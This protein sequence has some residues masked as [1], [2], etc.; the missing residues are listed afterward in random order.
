MTD[1]PAHQYITNTARTVAEVRSA[2]DDWLM[3]TKE[4]L[5]GSQAQRAPV[6]T[7]LAADEPIIGVTGSGAVSIDQ[8]TTTQFKNGRALLMLYAST[9]ATSL[10]IVHTASPAANN[11][12]VRGGVNFVMQPQDYILL[13]RDTGGVWREVARY[14][15][16]ATALQTWLGLG[17]AAY[18]DEGP[19]NGLDA[20]TLDGVQGAGYLLVA[21]QAADSAKLGTYLASEWLR[22]TDTAL[23]ILS[24]GLQSNGSTFELRGPTTQVVTLYNST[25]GEDRLVITS[26]ETQ[27]KLE[28]FGP[29]AVPMTTLRV[30]YSD[31]KLY[32]T[33]NYIGPTERSL[34]PGAGSG[35]DAD[36]LDGEQL[37]TILA[38]GGFFQPCTSDTESVFATWTPVTGLTGVAVPGTPNS[39]RTYLLAAR[40]LLYCT[41]N[42]TDNIRIRAHVGPLGTTSDP[43][44][45]T[46]PTE[47]LSSN[48][49]DYGRFDYDFE[50]VPDAGDKVTI[51]IWDDGVRFEVK[52]HPTASPQIDFGSSLYQECR[53]P[54]SYIRIQRIL[55]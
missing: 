19:G 45:Y 25:A 33:H 20:D 51:A 54:G 12:T 29:G 52:A 11:I 31:G 6:A 1:F 53:G 21:A 9:G 15:G 38:L 28:F 34:T 3:A 17:S 43:V 5:A 8:I 36:L 42:G 16:T 48:L 2:M 26:S 46:S 4:L 23:Q 39:V 27:C 40:L 47:Q 22:K 37:S 24:G 10:T 18:I 14:E 41:D 35:L 13:L 55:T 50:F 7:V 32:H 30:D 49:G 44:V